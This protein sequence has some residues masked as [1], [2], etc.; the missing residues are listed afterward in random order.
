M[1]PGYLLIASYLVTAAPK[2]ILG[3][4]PEDQ[5]ITRRRGGN[6]TSVSG[7]HRDFGWREWLYIG[8]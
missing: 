5:E 6:K 4:E 7:E 2:K 3:E 1:A 8:R